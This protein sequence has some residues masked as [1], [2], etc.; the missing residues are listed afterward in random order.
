MK[1]AAFTDERKTIRTYI[2][3]LQGQI[4][5]YNENGNGST[6]HLNAGCE[7]CAPGCKHSWRHSGHIPRGVAHIPCISATPQA[8]WM[9]PH[10]PHQ[11]EKEKPGDER[12]EPLEI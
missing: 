6:M 9:L 7:H 10:C 2:T 4:K 8:E 3:Y 12:P 11:R 1:E 5:R